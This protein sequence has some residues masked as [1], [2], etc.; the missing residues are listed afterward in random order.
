MSWTLAHNLS[1]REAAVKKCYPGT[2]VGSIGDQAH[3]AEHSDHNPDSRGVVHAIDIMLAVGNK[4]GDATLKWVLSAH[5]DLQYV[6]HNRIIYEASNSWK[7]AHYSGTDPH[8]NHIHV[9]GKHGSVGKNN[10]TGTGYDLVAEKSNPVGS[11]CAVVTPTPPE[12][13]VTKDDLKAIIDGVSAQV[14]HDIFHGAAQFNPVNGKYTLT[15][16][17]KLDELEAKINGLSPKA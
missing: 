6:I 7:G 14:V 2:V 1:V 17:G 13:E 10:A 3:Q 4:K 15:L 8:T 5:S 9:S 12:D 16:S 11:P